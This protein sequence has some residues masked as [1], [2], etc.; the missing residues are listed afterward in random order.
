MMK[1]EMKHK[2]MMHGEGMMHKMMKE[3][4]HKMMCHMKKMMPH[5]MMMKKK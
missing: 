3:M 2:S 1:K 5:K 4:M